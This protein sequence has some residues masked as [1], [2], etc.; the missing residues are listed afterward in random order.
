MVGGGGL[1][2]VWVSAH[3]RYNFIINQLFLLTLLL[4]TGKGWKKK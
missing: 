2:E 1:V 4:L 3:V